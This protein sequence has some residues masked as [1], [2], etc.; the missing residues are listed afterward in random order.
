ML[1]TPR[2]YVRGR[3]YAPAHARAT[4]LVTRGDRIV[5]VGD[6]VWITEGQI[7]HIQTND[8]TLPFKVVRRR[9]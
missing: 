4:A 5:F 1:S 7:F 9:I 8:P 2:A 6:D 3:V